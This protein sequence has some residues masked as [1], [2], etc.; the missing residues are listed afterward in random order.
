MPLHRTLSF[1][2]SQTELLP[3]AGE[4]VQGFDFLDLS[5]AARTHV[6]QWDPGVWGAANAAFWVAAASCHGTTA[7]QVQKDGVWRTWQGPGSTRGLLLATTGD[8]RA[9]SALPRGTVHPFAPTRQIPM[10]SSMGPSWFVWAGSPLASHCGGCRLIGARAGAA[11]SAGSSTPRPA[12]FPP[13]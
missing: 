12:P 11:G 9:T 8:D 2:G 1:P 4:P 3:S 6:W 10:G 5:P 13:G 7:G